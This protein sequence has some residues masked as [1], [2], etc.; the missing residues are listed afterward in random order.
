LEQWIELSEDPLDVLHN[1]V[2]EVLPQFEEEGKLEGYPLLKNDTVV[3]Y[4]Q[5]NT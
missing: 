1:L 5:V 3:Q 2:N 4:Y